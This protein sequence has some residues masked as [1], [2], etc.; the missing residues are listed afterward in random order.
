MDQHGGSI[1]GMGWGSVGDT[2]GQ[3]QTTGALGGEVSIIYEGFSLLRKKAKFTL[4]ARLLPG[5]CSNLNTLAYFRQP[6]PQQD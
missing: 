4:V 2:A 5:R 1:G 6:Q 3:S